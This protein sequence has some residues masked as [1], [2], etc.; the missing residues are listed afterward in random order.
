MYANKLPT[1][2][3]RTG[4]PNRRVSII[5]CFG[6]IQFVQT[7]SGLVISIVNKQITLKRL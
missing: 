7:L 5:L 4:Y 6:P 2:H 3:K 1:M